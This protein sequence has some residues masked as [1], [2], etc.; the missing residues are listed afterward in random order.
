MDDLFPPSEKF[1]DSMSKSMEKRESNWSLL[2]RLFS[3]ILKISRIWIGGEQ[4]DD[5]PSRGNNPGKSIEAGMNKIYLEN[6][7]QQ[8]E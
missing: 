4:G 2:S 6:R 3:F 8:A 1:C 7:V 5:I